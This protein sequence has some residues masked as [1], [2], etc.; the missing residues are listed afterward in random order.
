[1]FIN[2]CGG[3]MRGPLRWPPSP[4][5]G[6]FWPWHL[7]VVRRGQGERIGHQPAQLTGPRCRSTQPPPYLYWRRKTKFQRIQSLSG[8][9]SRIRHQSTAGGWRGLI[10]LVLCW[11]WR[12]P[13]D[14][15]SAFVKYYHR[16][17]NPSC[18]H[19]LLI[20]THQIN[21]SIWPWM[22]LHLHD[23]HEIWITACL[24]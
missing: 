7:G 22:Y 17:N 8:I 9:W 19:V 12:H 2:I 11:W 6:V 16:K 4:E 23:M 1:M 14:K 21:D 15:Q 24:C 20:M 18:P 3:G 13:E 10:R 5:P